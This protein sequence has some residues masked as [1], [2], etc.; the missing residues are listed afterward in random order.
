[1]KKYYL[2]YIC[3]YMIFADCCLAQVALYSGLPVRYQ[4]CN[5]CNQTQFN[6]ANG[7]FVYDPITNY[8]PEHVSSDYDM[9]DPGIKVLNIAVHQKIILV[10]DFLCHK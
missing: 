5:G 1:M 8:Q 7:S 4:R 9:R 6:D 3:V 2:V 10:V